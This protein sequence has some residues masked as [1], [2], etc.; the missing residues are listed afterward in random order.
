MRERSGHFASSCQSVGMLPSSNCGSY[1]AVTCFHLRPAATAYRAELLAEKKAAEQL[2]VEKQQL[3]QRQGAAE[4][5]L[6]AV[7]ADH[8]AL[9]QRQAASEV[10]HARALGELQGLLGAAQQAAAEARR[11]HDATAAAFNSAKATQ[12]QL[13]VSFDGHSMQLLGTCVAS[14]K[15]HVAGT[16]APHKSQ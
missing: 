15:R 4:A 11:A 12:Q 5:A 2:Q 14:E 6:A 3:V 8:T 7:R 16:P 1:G 9:Q 13:Q 10:E